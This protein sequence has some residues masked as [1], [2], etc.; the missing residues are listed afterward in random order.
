GNEVISRDG[1]EVPEKEIELLIPQLNP[2]RIEHG[3]ELSKT[4][5]ELRCEAKRKLKTKLIHSLVPR[6]CLYAIR[7]SWATQA[8][9]RGVDSITVAVLMGHADPSMLARVYQHL[10][11]NPQF[12][13]EQAKK[14]VD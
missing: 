4:L 3:R 9:E 1:I 6:Y 2:I 5:A 14:A 13:L 8:L 11:Q 10:A 7:H 12:M